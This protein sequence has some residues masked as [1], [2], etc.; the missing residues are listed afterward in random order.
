MTSPDVCVGA[1]LVLVWGM[2]WV[3]AKSG[4]IAFRAGLLEMRWGSR[5]GCV[6]MV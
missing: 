6:A 5:M 3:Q 2:N 1:I 4:I